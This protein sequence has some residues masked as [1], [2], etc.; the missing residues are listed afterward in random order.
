ME[1]VGKRKKKGRKEK[2]ISRWESRQRQAADFFFFF[3]FAAVYLMGLIL[4]I[5]PYGTGDMLL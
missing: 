5:Q 2:Q 4:I 3:F 1:G